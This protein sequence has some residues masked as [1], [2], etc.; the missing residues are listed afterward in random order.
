[1]FCHMSEHSRVSLLR[2]SDCRNL[3][4]IKLL[5]GCL[6]RASG[7]TSPRPRTAPHEV[8][9]LFRQSLLAILQETARSD[10][11]RT[12]RRPGTF[13]TRKLLCRRLAAAALRIA[14][15]PAHLSRAPCALPAKLRP[16]LYA[17]GP[18]RS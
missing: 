16:D 6:S 10:A 15:D 17:L 18:P 7:P 4:T 11:P 2:Y 12:Q 8:S 13:R 3:A 1:C 5:S 14:G 9:S